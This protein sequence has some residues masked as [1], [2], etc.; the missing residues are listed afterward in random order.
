MSSIDIYIFF[1]SKP[2]QMQKVNS[3]KLN[4][5]YIHQETWPPLAQILAC[6][7]FG[8]KPLSVAMLLFFVNV[9]VGI[10]CNEKWFKVEQLSYQKMMLKMP[11]K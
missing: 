1:T 4:D 6:C 2:F 9:P 5:T 3:P 7:M 11:A 8:A 10:N